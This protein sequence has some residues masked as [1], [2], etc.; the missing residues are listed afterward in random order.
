MEKLEWC[1]YLTVK[2]S[3]RICVTVSTEYQRVTDGQTSCDGIVRT[4]HSVAPSRYGTSRD[5]SATAELL[6]VSY[7]DVY[8]SCNS[9]ML[10]GRSVEIKLQT[11]SA[12]RCQ[13]EFSVGV[14][15]R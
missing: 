11:N 14:T 5:L 4:M 7:N 2:K 12:C 6:V 13:Q 3:L 1:G 9:M 15:G 10:F 8:A